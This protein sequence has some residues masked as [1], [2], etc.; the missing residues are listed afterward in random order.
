M[1]SHL[2]LLC[3]LAHLVLPESPQSFD[4]PDYESVD[5]SPIAYVELPQQV[6]IP[7]VNENCRIVIVY[8]ACTIL[9]ISAISFVAGIILFF[10]KASSQ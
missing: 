5:I 1:Y 9:I 4:I 10:I 6:I 2:L 3:L 8:I 7:D